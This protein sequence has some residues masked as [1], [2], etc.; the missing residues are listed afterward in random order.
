[1]DPCDTTFIITNQTDI[2]HGPLQQCQNSTV[3]AINVRKARGTLMFPFI[4][5]TYHV[6]VQDSPQLETLDFP[7]LN[8]IN[9][10][11]ISQATNLTSVLLPN[12]GSSYDC[13]QT[14]LMLWFNITSAPSLSNI[15][16][17][18]SECLGRVT[19]FDV[20]K[21]LPNSSEF[22]TQKIST[23]SI[24]TNICL[25]LS[26]LTLA[27]DLDLSGKSCNYYLEKLTEVRNFILRNA[28][29]ILPSLNSLEKA[30]NIYID[31][32]LDA[33]TGP[34]IFPALKS[35][36]NVTVNATNTFNCSMLVSQRDNQIIQNLQCIGEYDQPSSHGLAIGVRVGIGVGTGL[37]AIGILGTIIWLIIRYKRRVKTLETGKAREH[38]DNE[39][40]KEP[41]QSHISQQEVCGRG[42]FREMPDDPLVE[43]PT[44]PAEL[45]TRHHS[46]IETESGEAGRAL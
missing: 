31:G 20:P 27:R 46:R 42:I 12:L 4:T 41:E 13:S 37:V 35:A 16:L 18:D 40:S 26:G 38:E 11:N 28:D 6:D 25:D 17:G 30:E 22:D 5:Q 21:I 45:P 3:T 39:R 19:L 1:M 32:L 33:T 10:L 44:Q 24:Y 7:A 14:Q 15:T 23:S 43:M 8:Y 36:Q 29:A 34:N 9:T 2:D